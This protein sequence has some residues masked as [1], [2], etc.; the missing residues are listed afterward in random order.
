MTELFQNG[1][2]ETFEETIKTLEIFGDKSGLK[3]NIEKPFVVWMG[4]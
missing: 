2:R 1:D 3:L 4:T